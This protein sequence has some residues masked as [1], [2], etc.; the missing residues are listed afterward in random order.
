MNHGETDQWDVITGA[1]ENQIKPETVSLSL[2]A[3]ISRTGKKDQKTHGD[4]GETDPMRENRIFRILLRDCNERNRALRKIVGDYRAKE[5]SDAADKEELYRETRTR[6]H[7]LLR[8]VSALRGLIRMSGQ[9][10][11]QNDGLSTSEEPQCWSMASNFKDVVE[12]QVLPYVPDYT[13]HWFTNEWTALYR[14]IFEWA[15]SGYR[16]ISNHPLKG[17]GLQQM[18]WEGVGTCNDALFAIYLR[19]IA[20]RADVLESLVDDPKNRTFVCI[21]LVYRILHEEVFEGMRNLLNVEI[22]DPRVSWMHK[23]QSDVRFL[24]TTREDY[25]RLNNSAPG[26]E[27]GDFLND[28]APA[29]WKKRKYDEMVTRNGGENGVMDGEVLPEEDVQVLV[30]MNSNP[31]KRIKCEVFKEMDTRKMPDSMG[32]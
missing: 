16:F 8:E 27:G 15:D 9:N 6:N 2:A 26:G 7:E 24:T 10:D 11:G 5:N 32:E 14:R 18:F 25:Q 3:H 29:T 1:V 12:H 21:G 28:G 23:E 4:S 22:A 17:S 31:S 20:V 19:D 30:L 13:D